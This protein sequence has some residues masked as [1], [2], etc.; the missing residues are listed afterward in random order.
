MLYSVSPLSTPATLNPSHSSTATHSEAVAIPSAE[1][2]QIRLTMFQ[3]GACPRA[4]ESLG[5]QES[6]AVA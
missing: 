5:K 4:R 3:A 2:H 6:Y 1:D